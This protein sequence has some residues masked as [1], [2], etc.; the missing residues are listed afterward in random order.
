MSA[1]GKVE[2]VVIFDSELRAMAR[3]LKM[4]VELQKEKRTPDEIGKALTDYFTTSLSSL[5]HLIQN[6]DAPFVLLGSKELK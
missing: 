5:H 1:Q 4:A 6:P 3:A 2:V